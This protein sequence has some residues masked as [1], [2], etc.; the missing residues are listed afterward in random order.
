MK[1]N[2]K[3][4]YFF[5]QIQRLFHRLINVF[6]VL[7]YKKK[8]KKWEITAHTTQSGSCKEMCHK[9]HRW[10]E[11]VTLLYFVYTRN[12]YALCWS[13]SFFIKDSFNIY[14]VKDLYDMLLW[15]S[16]L[17]YNKYIHLRAY[18]IHFSGWNFFAGK[19]WFLKIFE[20]YFIA[21]VLFKSNFTIVLEGHSID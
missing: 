21:S 5:L 18:F 4:Q 7:N 8:W 16:L 12:E 9:I 6:L 20:N 11:L 2:N 14:F 19:K 17:S 3:G 1:S 10:P 15:S 13:L